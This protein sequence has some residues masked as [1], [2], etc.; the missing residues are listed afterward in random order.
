MTVKRYD[1]GAK[2]QLKL[3]KNGYLRSQAYVTRIGVFKYVRDDG[4]IVKEL[5]HPDDVFKKDSIDTLKSIPVTLDHPDTLV[6]SENSQYLQ[7]G[8]TGDA[9]NIKDNRYLETAI[10]VT[11]KDAIEE[12]SEGKYEIS[13]GYVCDL[14]DEQGVYDGE[15]YDCRQTKID[16]NHVAIVKSGRAGEKVKIKLDSGDAI[17]QT[18]QKKDADLTVNSKGKR[19]ASSLIASGKVNKTSSWS[20][21]TKDANKIL[22]DPPVWEEYSGW[23]LS[24]DASE[25]ADSKAR[26]KFPFGKNGQVYRSAL[27]AAKQRAGQFKHEGILEEADKLLEKIDKK[28]KKDNIS[29]NQIRQELRNLMTDKLNTDDFWMDEIFEDHFIFGIGM[30]LFWQNYARINN[31]FVLV[32]EPIKVVKQIEFKKRE[33]DMSLKIKI[34]KDEIKVDEETVKD[35]Q[36]KIDALME[37]NEELKTKVTKDETQAKLDALEEENKKLKEKKDSDMISLLNE[38]VALYEVAKKS[39]DED[40]VKKLDEMDNMAIKKAIVSKKTDVKLDDKSEEYIQARYDILIENQDSA[41]DDKRNLGQHLSKKDGSEGDKVTHEDA[42]KERA[43][44][45]WKP[46]KGGE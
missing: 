2:V 24:V 4:K 46:K 6:D 39:C 43:L 28:I 25:P 36:T 8:W 34:N 16:Y 32:G 35:V 26:Y 1:L 20:F 5:R 17:M 21:S 18:E 33:D 7:K 30:D 38:R 10:N 3:D 42:M 23:F 41:E 9:V 45:A 12:I 13:C 14:K 40:T 29:F 44:N 22:G 37:E 11:T 31:K 27:I 19:N 15:K